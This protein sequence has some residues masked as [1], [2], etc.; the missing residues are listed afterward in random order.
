M[1]GRAGTFRVAEALLLIAATRLRFATPHAADDTV[2][3]DIP[4][5][6]SRS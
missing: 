2:D 3:S 4:S 1:F 6:H 5:T